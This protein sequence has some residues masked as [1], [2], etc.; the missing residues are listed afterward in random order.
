MAWHDVVC[1]AKRM[2]WQHNS[3]LASQNRNAWLEMNCWGNLTSPERI[4]LK[5]N[6]LPV[7][8][9]TETYMPAC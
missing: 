1:L 2:F 9:D 5:E 7:A 8:F 3:T 4:D 6:V